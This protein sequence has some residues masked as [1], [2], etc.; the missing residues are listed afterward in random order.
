MFEMYESISCVR[1]PDWFEINAILEYEGEGEREIKQE[2]VARKKKWKE[3]RNIAKAFPGCSLA[4]IKYRVALLYT[5]CNCVS[6]WSRFSPLSSLRTRARDQREKRKTRRESLGEIC[7]NHARI[8]VPSSDYI[9]KGDYLR[10]AY[11]RIGKR[12]RGG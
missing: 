4:D 11:P 10:V 1:D 9:T 6:N 5:S 12:E 8:F 7:L 3:K 2:L